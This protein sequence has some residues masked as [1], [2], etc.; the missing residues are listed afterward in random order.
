MR[1]QREPKVTLD[2]KALEVDYTTGKM[3]TKRDYERVA[4]QWETMEKALKEREK[5]EQ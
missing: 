5:K 3:P 1:K 2:G 4:K